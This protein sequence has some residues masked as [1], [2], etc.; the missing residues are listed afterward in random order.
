MS[1]LAEIYRQEKKSGGGLTSTITKR[2]GEK[3]DPRQMLDSSGIIA[4]MFPGLKPYSATPKKTLSTASSMPSISLGAGELSLISEATKITAKNSIV[5][6]SMARD[7]FLVKQ[8]IIKL[9]KT[10]GIKP[11]TRSGD[12]LSRQ[13]ARE[14][15]F[16]QQM[17]TMGRKAGSVGASGGIEQETGGSFLDKIGAIFG[18]PMF[19]KK[20]PVPSTPQPK[21]QYRDPKTGRFAK[22]PPPATAASRL[23]GLSTT[24]ARALP[25][26][27]SALLP[28]LG[29]AGLAGL[30][31]YLIKNDKGKGLSSDDIDK[32]N[33]DFTPDQQI[34]ASSFNTP[35]TDD[36]IRKARENMRAS[37]NPDVRAAAAKLDVTNPLPTI[38]PSP[39]PIITQPQPN[40]SPVPSNVVTSGSGSPIMTGAGVP[41]TT[42]ESMSPTQDLSIGD[43]INKA[44]AVTGVSAQTLAIFGQLESG[45]GKIVENKLSSARGPF[46]FIES[47]WLTMLQKYGK[48]HGYD[49]SSMTR[50]EQLNLRYN[51][52]ASAIMAAE[53]TKENAATLGI[54]PSD[55][56]SVDKLYLAHF[57][58]PGGAKRVLSGEGLTEQQ[59][60]IVMKYN[61]NIT[62]GSKEEFLQFAKSKTAEAARVSAVQRIATSGATIA[63]ASTAAADARQATGGRG[64]VA[65]DNSQ[66]TTVAAAPTAGRPASAY[67]KDIVDALMGSTYA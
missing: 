67:D 21:G 63:S 52:R 61:P 20:A 8:N 23:G 1:R 65:I 43:A 7:M 53:Y 39:Q 14:A 29:I 4:T 38:S 36:E 66:R 34:T 35:G 44:T 32:D 33:L 28:V 55:P 15:A 56:T 54:N 41:L 2:L 64:S 24:L 30:L 60:A 25:F 6:P 12:F 57:L 13:F 45:L 9:V 22:R 47:T 17:A 50:E 18:F 62:T 42:G 48:K 26:L 16:E 19:G 10:T 3:I 27:S 40:V 31:V 51:N 37:D 59:K 11:Q 58:G 5:L 46:Q 49:P